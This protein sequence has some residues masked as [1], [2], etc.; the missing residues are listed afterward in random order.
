MLSVEELQNLNRMM[1]GLGAPTQY[2][3]K[4]YSQAHYGY[5]YSLYE[6]Y[7]ITEVEA[8][9]LVNALLKYKKTQ[10]TEYAKDLEETAL[11]LRNRVK[12]VNVVDFNSE[13]VKIT[14]N[15]S[16]RVADFIKFEMD[17]ST[18]KW[19]KPANDWVLE[20]NWNVIAPLLEVFNNQ[21]YV[22]DDVEV[23]FQHRNDKK[24]VA[25]PKAKLFKLQ[26]TRP[27]TTIDTLS[28]VVPYNKALVDVFHSIADMYF[29]KSQKEWSVYIESANDLYVALEQLGNVDTSELKPW[30]NL[31]KSWNKGYELVDY[32]K[33][34][35]KF[36]PYDFQIADAR[37]LLS[38]KVMLNANDMGAGKTFESVLIGES[39]PMKKL[40]ICPPSLRLNWKKEIQMVNP[41]ANI[42]II[43]SKDDFKVVDGWN[44]IG[45]PSIDKF[46][47]ELE[48]EFFQVVFM[49]EAHY[50][51]A[52]T[53]S[54]QPDSKRAYGV[55]RIAS[56][57]NYVYPITGTPKTNRNKNLYNI[58]R[59]IRHPL[60]RGRYAFSHYGKEYCGGKQTMWGW[61]FNGNSNDKDLNEQIVPFMVRHLKSEVLPNLH[62]QRIVTPVEVDLREYKQEVEEYL[63]LRKNKNAEALAR[64]M[65]AKQ[66]LAIQ[67]AKDSI[68]FAESIIAE[69]KKAV[70]V[71]C[72]TEVVNQVMKAFKGNVVKLV[73]G[74]SDKQKD[75]AITEF[76]EGE[77]QVMVM[78]IVA[79]GVGVTLTKAHNMII[80]DFDWVP[81]N[82][83]QAEDRICRVG[84]KEFCT[85]YYLYAEGAD[86]DEV[87][88]NTLTYKFET[89]NNVIDGGEGDAIDYLSL[90]ISA[91]K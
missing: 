47:K 46:Q 20:V 43:Y 80:N 13:W 59:T 58:L 22:L 48:E 29:N 36:K 7:D 70:I 33:L 2:D 82:L 17:K 42:H 78:N 89:I 4:G 44:I 55:L 79:G 45:Y 84:Q 34:P 61:D 81:G 83:T 25:V 69:G 60:A 53:N 91:L 39:I 30:A 24:T 15:Y 49:D 73:G 37:E 10:L 9:R 40:V 16:K 77:S 68:E 6:K 54:G 71:T 41:N 63:K 11:A 50:I 18:C 66:I 23:A 27:S 74:M 67:K 12:R 88:A 19:R 1:L 75:Q 85:I 90:I 35:L 62:K 21:G 28:I 31:V 52:V 64:L 3:D 72:F 38:K 5:M 56:T 32:T 51:Q 14:W 86:M 87:L 76:Q 8:E 57:A 26:V 65:K